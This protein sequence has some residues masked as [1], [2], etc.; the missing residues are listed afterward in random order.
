MNNSYDYIIIGGGSAGC[1]LANRLSEN[2]RWQVC[3]IEAGPRDTNPFINIPSGIIPLNRSNVL[4][5]KFQTIAQAHCANRNMFWPRGR[6]LGGS[7]AINAMCYIRGRAEDYDAWSQLGNKG[8]SFEEV[9]PYFLKLENFEPGVNAYHQQGGPINVSVHRDINPLATAFVAAG[10]QAGFNLTDDFNGES[11]EGIGYYHVT[12]KEGQRCSNAHAYLHPVEDRKNLTI[13]TQAQVSKILFDNNSAMGVRCHY[14][15]QS[16]DILARKEVILSA[17]V[18]GSPQLLLLSGVGPSVELTKQ[19]ISLVQELPG[20]G[21]NLQ[22]HPY[23][24]IS[25]LEKTKYASSFLL[26]ALFRNIKN[27]MLFYYNHTGELTSNIIQAGGFIKSSPS[28]TIANLQLNF[29]PILN[30]HHAQDL[31]LMFKYYG[32]SVA[33]YILNPKSR[34]RITLQNTDVSSPPLINPNYLSDET[35]LD[36]LVLACKIVRNILQQPAFAAHSLREFAPGEAV[37][38]DQ[39][40]RDY[41]RNNLETAYH[42]VGTCKMGVDKMAVVDPQLKVHGVNN[43]RV[44]DASIMPII[45][46][47]NTN[48]PTTM[49]AEKAADM[50]LQEAIS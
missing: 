49:I 48:T 37:Q 21:E 8:W 15:G 18:I 4:N 39:Q 34:G 47:G 40:L 31:T 26:S 16:Q 12:E 29:V 11:P 25:Y 32:Y 36:K 27:I 2:S 22:D 33:P 38:T 7:S 1:V 44:V 41:I 17:G 30:V 45:V 35:D 23:V 20:V 10:A 24:F 46:R 50:I 3:L 42:P 14:Q 5:W 28:E 43:L 19:G 6:T 13:M 9:L